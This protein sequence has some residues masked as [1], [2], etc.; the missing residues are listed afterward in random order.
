MTSFGCPSAHAGVR[1]LDQSDTSVYALCHGHRP[2]HRESRISLESQ[3]SQPSFP[4]DTDI[5]PF[6]L[7]SHHPRP[8]TQFSPIFAPSA[9]LSLSLPWLKPP[10]SGKA[11]RTA[12]YQSVTE[13]WHRP[14]DRRHVRQGHVPQALSTPNFDRQITAILRGFCQTISSSSTG[15]AGHLARV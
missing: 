4:P 11:P 12:T 9:V 7:I 13:T 2:S 1:V 14:L 15:P 10:S 3:R 8:M 6:P 5:P